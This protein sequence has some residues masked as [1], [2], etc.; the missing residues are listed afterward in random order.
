[1]VDIFG[2]MAGCAIDTRGIDAAA[3]IADAGFAPAS[4]LDAALAKADYV[5]LHQVLT[6]RTRGLFGRERLFAM[7][8][9]AALI[10]TAR[11]ALVDTDGLIEAVRCG[12]LRGA[13][14]DVFDRE[15]LP[16]DHPLTRADGILLSPHIGGATEEAMERTAIQVAEAVIAA[17]QGRRPD[18]LVNPDVWERRRLAAAA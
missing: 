15:P 13:A 17:L 8:K 14:M 11:G 16:S 5:S 3:E 1:M 7:K 4:D 9:G 12:H 6:E 10:N 18:H 2:Q